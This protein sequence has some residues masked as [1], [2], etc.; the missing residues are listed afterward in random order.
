LELNG[1]CSVTAIA[2]K[3]GIEFALINRQRNGKNANAPDRMDLLVGDVRDK[4]AI[5]VD[6]M[7][8]TGKTL[9]LA[10]NTLKEKGAKAIYAIISHGA[11]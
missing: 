1:T 8:D 5:L 9:A 7:I 2:D 11:D 10:V 6:D 4:V 3:L